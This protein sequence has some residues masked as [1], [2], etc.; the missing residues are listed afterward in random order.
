MS[1]SSRGL[2]QAVTLP[3]EDV[4]STPQ[5]MFLKLW[6]PIPGGWHIVFSEEFPEAHSLRWQEMPFNKALK[7]HVMQARVS[8]AENLEPQRTHASNSDQEV[9]DLSEGNAT[10]RQGRLLQASF[11]IQLKKCN[12]LKRT[13][14]KE[15][16]YLEGSTGIN[17]GGPLGPQ[18]NYHYE[19]RLS[20]WAIQ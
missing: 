19:T 12:D 3:L 15:Y 11:P 9:A 13:T 4:S 1:I 5:D 10:R 2:G 14:W 17:T 20:A 7:G 6:R 16:L 18:L 8:R